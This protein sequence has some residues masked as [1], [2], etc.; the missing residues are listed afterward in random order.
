MEKYNI[1]D[2]VYPSIAL[3]PHHNK[4]EEERK[5]HIIYI[6]DSLPQVNFDNSM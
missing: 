3:Q 1:Y 5:K 2:N 6:L 4:N